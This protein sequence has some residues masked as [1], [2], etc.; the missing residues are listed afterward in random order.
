MQSCLPRLWRIVPVLLENAG[1]TKMMSAQHCM[2]ASKLGCKYSN[3]L[4]LILIIPAALT[5]VSWW[6]NLRTWK[7]TRQPLHHFKQS[8]ILHL[9][10]DKSLIFTKAKPS[11]YR[12]ALDASPRALSCAAVT[13]T[14]TTIV[15]MVSQNPV[16]YSIYTLIQTITTITFT[17]TATEKTALAA[18]ST[19]VS[20]AITII[21]AE[22]SHIQTTLVCKFSFFWT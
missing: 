20:A 4:I 8:L 13:T 21:A 6:K 5:Q 17:C 9:Q 1:N 16:S 14:S 22:V 3:L 2:L 18:V 7:R 10:G 15:S 11:N 12:T 19:S